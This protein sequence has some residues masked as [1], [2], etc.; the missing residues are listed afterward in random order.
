MVKHT[1]RPRE[2]CC[3]YCWSGNMWCL[4]GQKRFPA[5]IPNR[6]RVYVYWMGV[7]LQVCARQR[8]WRW[9]CGTCKFSVSFLREGLRLLQDDNYQWP[10][11]TRLLSLFTELPLWEMTNQYLI[12]GQIFAL[13]ERKSLSS[14]F[15]PHSI[16]SESLC[17]LAVWI[18]PVVFFF[19]CQQWV[20]RVERTIIYSYYLFS[21]PRWDCGIREDCTIHPPL[22]TSN[23]FIML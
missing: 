6:G 8:G 20:E 14:P 12:P 13:C 7:Y 16:H 21:P 17:V 1:R 10:P 19:L 9:I 5:W 3:S 22:C 4:F 11:V 2:M 15:H 18:N 23:D